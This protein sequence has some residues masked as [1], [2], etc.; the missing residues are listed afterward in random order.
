MPP[1]APGP[2]AIDAVSFLFSAAVLAG[3]RLP[4]APAPTRRRGFFADA[5][6]GMKLLAA[7][8]GSHGLRDRPETAPP[9]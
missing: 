6:D 1:S 2:L 5:V 4:A 8:V 7:A 3:L 9:N